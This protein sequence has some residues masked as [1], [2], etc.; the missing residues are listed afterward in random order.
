MN[1][2]YFINSAS[3]TQSFKGQ[4]LCINTRDCDAPRA[5]LIKGIKIYEEV[6]VLS[7]KCPLC[8]TIYYADIETSA[9]IDKNNGDD[10][11]TK[12]YLNNAKYLKVE[13]SVWV[14]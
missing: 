1:R 10:N 7:G 6:Y 3:I 5:T 11:G 4:S 2:V 13:R 8:Q 12:F 14:D 9:P